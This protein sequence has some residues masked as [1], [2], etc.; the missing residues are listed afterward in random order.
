[1]FSLIGYLFRVK[2]V[3]GSSTPEGTEELDELSDVLHIV[4]L[5]VREPFGGIDQ[6]E[7]CVK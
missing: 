2:K 6:E 4:S 7:F 5:Q 1:M 3:F